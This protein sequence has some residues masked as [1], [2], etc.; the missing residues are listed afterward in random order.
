[1]NHLL[2]K[3]IAFTLISLALIIYQSLFL[4]ALQTTMMRLA[5]E[6]WAYRQIQQTSYSKFVFSN[7]EFFKILP[8]FC[9]LLLCITLWK[10]H[11]TNI[12]FTLILCVVT[13]FALMWSIYDPK[14]LA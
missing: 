8:I 9:F 10:F 4:Y 2:F 7:I 1:M 13:I 6:L 3:K 5:T 14:L 12:C 11:K